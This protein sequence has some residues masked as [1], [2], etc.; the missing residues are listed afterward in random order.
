VLSGQEAIDKIKLGN[1]YI[2]QFSWIT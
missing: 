2:A 1:P